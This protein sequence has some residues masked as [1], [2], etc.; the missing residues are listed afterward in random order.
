M[1]DLIR[2]GGMRNGVG[3]HPLMRGRTTELFKAW[4]GVDYES[5]VVKLQT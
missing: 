2:V 5:V 1:E 4:L 3:N